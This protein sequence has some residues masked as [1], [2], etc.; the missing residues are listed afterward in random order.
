MVKCSTAEEYFGWKGLYFPNV[1]FFKN[2][3]VNMVT[4]VLNSTAIYCNCCVIRCDYTYTSVARWK[5]DD[6][7]C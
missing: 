2:A 5:H 3:F 7:E 1:N 4:V 6:L